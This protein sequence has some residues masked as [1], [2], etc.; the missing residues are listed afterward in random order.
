M[1]EIATDNL[2]YVECW[3]EILTP[4]WVRF[5]HL[6]SGNGKIHSDVADVA[7]VIST[8]ELLPTFSAR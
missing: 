8:C 5:R 4:K 1:P 6:L 2:G 3:N 7:F